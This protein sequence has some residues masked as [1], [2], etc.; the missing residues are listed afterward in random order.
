MIS[1]LLML[2]KPLCF[3]KG[4]LQRDKSP[5]MSK[6]KLL[7]I[8]KLEAVECRTFPVQSFL[9][10]TYLCGGSWVHSAQIT[11]G[12][13]TPPSPLQPWLCCG[14]SQKPLSSWQHAGSRTKAMYKSPIK[15]FSCSPPCSNGPHN[16]IYN[17]RVGKT[18]S[19]TRN[20]K[21]MALLV[22][23]PTAHRP[24]IGTEL[25]LFWL[26]QAR[27]LEIFYEDLGNKTRA[28]KAKPCPDT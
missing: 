10:L 22:I 9:E 6:T 15:S 5:A 26:F 14:S 21:A 4:L 16:T 20:H 2:P 3:L 17:A 27:H 8:Y 11:E 25:P 19:T 13:F 18:S 7:R 28:Q 24:Q 23:F 1:K 12:C